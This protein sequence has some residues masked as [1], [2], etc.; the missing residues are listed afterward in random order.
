M[1]QPAANEISGVT[2]E[3]SAATANVVI[4]TSTTDRLAIGRQLARIASRLD[5]RAALYSN[6]GMMSTSTRCGS[7]L[8]F[9]PGNAA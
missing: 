9:G 8:R 6:G 7:S 1:T 4:S 5:R 2:T 3:E